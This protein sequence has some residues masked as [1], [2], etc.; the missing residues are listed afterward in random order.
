VPV[1][2]AATAGAG[3]QEHVRHQLPGPEVGRS[4]GVEPEL[5]VQV[6]HPK[7]GAQHLAQQHVDQDEVRHHRGSRRC[8][9]GAVTAFIM[10]RTVLPVPPGS[11]GDQYR[12]ASRGEVRHLA[13]E[14]PVDQV[15]HFGALQAAGA[16]VGQSAGHATRQRSVPF[17]LQRAALVLHLLQQPLDQLRSGSSTR[18]HRAVPFT[19]KLRPLK[20][21]NW[22]PEARS[23]GSRPCTRAW[24]AGVQ[25]HRHG[26][27][28][29]LSRSG[30]RLQVFHRAFIEDA[31][32]RTL[33]I[34]HHQACAQLRQ[35]VAPCN[36][37]TGRTPVSAILAHGSTRTSSSAGHHAP[38]TASGIVLGHRAFHRQVEEPLP[39]RRR[40]P[41]RPCRPPRP[42]GRGDG[43]HRVHA[44]NT[45][46]RP[47]A[48]A[49]ARS[50]GSG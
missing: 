11:V 31:F 44:G 27:E 47:A 5:L 1:P 39:A 12:P 14:E 50:R 2:V 36:W 26:K 30:P 45:R 15:V 46:G 16:P 40:R 13:G 32:Q 4:D 9:A 43:S 23:S 38:G 21:S 8:M 7:V 42:A 22:K 6:R 24:S 20:G 19:A 29:G 18:L 28:Q 33:L 35:D 37:N 3:V 48:Q 10:R 34:D 25:F 17:R 41:C 49:Q